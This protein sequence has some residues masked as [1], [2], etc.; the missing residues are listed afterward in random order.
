MSVLSTSLLDSLS[1]WLLL[2]RGCSPLL[3][4]M[5]WSILEC[6]GEPGEAVPIMG[7]G[8]KRCTHTSD[9]RGLGK[10]GH[11]LGVSWGPRWPA[12]LSIGW[13]WDRWS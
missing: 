8:M 10:W 11:R 12:G 2:G 7:G 1:F 9:K 5:G 4:P 13:D 6:L 3:V